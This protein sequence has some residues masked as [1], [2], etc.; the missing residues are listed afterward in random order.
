MMRIVAR[1]NAMH[2]SLSRRGNRD[3]LVFTYP[4][5]FPFLIDQYQ[6]SRLRKESG[7]KGQNIIL[8]VVCFSYFPAPLSHASCPA[9]RMTGLIL[10]HFRFAGHFR[11]FMKKEKKESCSSASFCFP[12]ALPLFRFMFSKYYYHHHSDKFASILAFLAHC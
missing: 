8:L 9:F 4:S 5:E 3:G 12:F 7:I 1:M 11:Y 2:S 6:N 10:I